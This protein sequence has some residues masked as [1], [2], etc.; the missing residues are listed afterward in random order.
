MPADL[1]SVITLVAL[2]D[3]FVL[4]PAIGARPIRIVLSL[5]LLL[6]LPGYALVA[7]LFP[8]RDRTA[9]ETDRSSGRVVTGRLLSG[10]TINGLERVLLSVGT[11]ITVVPLIGLILDATPLGLRPAPIVLSVSAFTVVATIVGI[12]RRWALDK[13]ARF[14]VPIQRWSRRVRAGLTPESRVDSLLNVVFVVSLLILASTI[15]YTTVVP[16]EDEQFSEFYLLTENSSG[17][18][19][20]DNY[21][22]SY[23]PG[24]TNSLI[25]GIT[26]HEGRPMNYTVVIQFQRIA[27]GSDTTSVV[28][29][30]RLHQF[31]TEIE[32]NETQLRRHAIEPTLTG[33]RLRLTYL[34]YRGP[35]PRNPTVANAYR[36]THLWIDVSDNG[37]SA[38]IEQDIEPLSLDS[39]SLGPHHDLPGDPRARLGPTTQH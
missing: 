27:S 3:V 15:A 35:A 16:R 28:E 11:S 1:A 38:H 8:E 20:A 39:L 25:I 21:P 34:L 33:P 12:S 30:R 2:T 36:E 14:T 31:E 7:A 4:I 6:V 17:E 32:A 22:A 5:L 24:E 18:L 9:T 26:N 37:S 23:R 19:V 10:R 13:Q 29:R